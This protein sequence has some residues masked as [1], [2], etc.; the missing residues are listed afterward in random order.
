MGSLQLSMVTCL[1]ELLLICFSHYVPSKQGVV[2]PLLGMQSGKSMMTCYYIKPLP[3]TSPTT[4]MS[5]RVLAVLC[6]CLMA[7]QSSDL[8][9]QPLLRHFAP[10]AVLW[11]VAGVG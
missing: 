2:S 4:E 8:L 5:A 3:L 9:K 10:F 11:V 1:T 6:A 7:S